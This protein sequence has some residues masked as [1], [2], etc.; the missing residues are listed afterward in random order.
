[1]KKIIF[2]VLP[3]LFATLQGEI[4]QNPDIKQKK[5]D[6]KLLT[7]KAVSYLKSHDIYDACHVFSKDP[8]WRKGDLCVTLFKKNGFIYTNP[9]DKQT[10]WQNIETI[11]KKPYSNLMDKM[12]H[13]SQ[14]GGGWVIYPWQKNLKY[15]YVQSVEK[16]EETFFVTVGFYPQ[17]KE[18]QT[19]QLVES[20]IHIFKDKSI[21]TALKSI[22]KPEFQ[23]GAIYIEI[24]KEDGTCIG[25]G[26]NQNAVGKNFLNT[27]D[28]KGF[29]FI[30]QAI[31]ITQEKPQDWLEYTWKN[32]KKRSYIKRY[33]DP[34]T[35]TRYIV[36]AGYY[37]DIDKNM[38][39]KFVKKAATYLTINDLD[40]SLKQF[41]NP[42]GQFAQGPL[43]IMLLDENGTQLTD[44]YKGTTLSSNFFKNLILEA[45]NNDYGWSFGEDRFTEAAAYAEKIRS[46]QITYYVISIYYLNSKKR[47]TEQFVEEASE[48]LLSEKPT[49]AFKK[50]SNPHGDF[51]RGDQYIFVYDITGR[52]KAHGENTDFIQRDF[53]ALTDQSGTLILEQLINLAR[54]QQSGWI[55]FEL[56]NSVRRTYIRRID[57]KENKEEKSYIV[58]S[59]FWV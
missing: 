52:C 44:T 42:K 41:N 4:N 32:V 6:I 36:M 16:G 10:I 9:N 59:G 34:T 38:V 20:V 46:N 40:A 56:R 22:S 49:S 47:S 50:Y 51:I 7:K 53:S 26:I 25:N 24:Y 15:S 57:I 58:G 23:R 21:K 54:K 48:I 27:K 13:R 19:K 5:R 14:E 37:P 3:L 11:D 33:I 30:K 29:S 8:S 2:L 39:P 43:E 35:Q 18:F 1:M 12:N 45:K 17:S 31:K 28:K 55:N